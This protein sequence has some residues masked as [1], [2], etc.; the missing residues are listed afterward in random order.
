MKDGQEPLGNIE[1]LHPDPAVD[2]AGLVGSLGG[3]WPQAP[4]VSCRWCL[5]GIHGQF[6]SSVNSCF[7]HT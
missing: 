6:L 5:V 4:R 1:G 2:P 7:F 3:I